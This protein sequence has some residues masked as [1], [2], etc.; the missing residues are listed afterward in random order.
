VDYLR[1]EHLRRTALIEAMA[2]R[3]FTSPY[4]VAKIFSRYAVDPEGALKAAEE[5]TV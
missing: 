1:Q 2:R 5:G 4:I 3:G